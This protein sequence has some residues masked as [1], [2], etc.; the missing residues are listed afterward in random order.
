MASNTEVIS[1]LNRLIE[2]CRDGQEGFKTAAGG[3]RSAELKSLFHEYSQQRARF[4]GELQQEVRRMGGEAEDAGSVSAALHRGWIGLKSALTGE[5]DGAILTECERGE[6]A[7]VASYRSALGTDLPA[8][9]RGVVERQFSEVKQAHER[10]R[11]L[12][13]AGGANA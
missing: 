9:V 8:N 4:V 1:A 2:T 5:D 12:E 10:V 7:A 13:E 6:D 3:V 11:S